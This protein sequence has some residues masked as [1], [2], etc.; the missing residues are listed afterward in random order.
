MCHV[1]ARS[2]WPALGLL[3]DSVRLAAELQAA[4]RP[5]EAVPHYEAALLQLDSAGAADIYSDLGIALN[6]A[7]RRQEAFDAYETC[8]AIN[9]NH[10]HA[11][12]NLAV[13]RQAHGNV[14]AALVAYT[15]AI[16]LM[17]GLPVLPLN[18]LRC[19]LDG[20][21][22]RAWP[23][24]E[25]LSQHEAA[26][27]AAS[28]IDGTAAW[29]WSRLEARA[30]LVDSATL[31]HAAAAAEASA[32]EAAARARWSGCHSACI[33]REAP[34]LSATRVTPHEGRQ[35][36]RVA[37]LSDLDADP[38]ASLLVD[39]LP[40]LHRSKS[41]RLSLLAT[42]SRAPS[43]HLERIS[44]EVPTYWL[45]AAPPSLDDRG[46]GRELC[47]AQGA[48]HELR[49]HIILE[50]MGYLPGQQLVLLA[51]N[52]TRAPVHTSWMR[53]FH[54]SMRAR[55]IHYTL[56]DA[57]ALTVALPKAAHG[58]ALSEAAILMPHQHLAH[59]HTQST[60]KPGERGLRGLPSTWPRYVPIAC[61]LNRV[62]KLEP[63]ILDVWSSALRRARIPIWLHT[64]AGAWTAR[65][66]REA[67]NALRGEAMARGMSRDQLLFASRSPSFSGHMKRVE[68]CALALDGRRWGAHTTALDALAVG[69]GVLSTPGE[70]LAARASHSLAHAI[71]APTLSSHSLREHSDLAHELLATHAPDGRA[72]Y[73]ELRAMRS[74]H[75][76]RPVPVE[77]D[78]VRL[79]H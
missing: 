43:E 20:A 25:R 24:L 63:S 10:G 28:A 66:R 68:R 54:G 26:P 67:N 45:P 14:D 56:V 64:G 71:G 18:A 44:R 17:P 50:A 39:V 33:H 11:Y 75:R 13:A 73:D 61:S 31:L 32:V 38:S 70:A 79:R 58:R 48:L 36:L 22:W 62:N 12:N 47:E 9:P 46:A 7:G 52:C 15:Q 29:P 72:R 59:S 55:F 40:L 19:K 57:R 35:P 65:G 76:L 4:G 5:A 53:A 51:R 6:Q 1:I 42:P 34:S 78:S 77:A 23:Q 37:L 49:P 74:R 60:D 30:F 8:L 69:V 3:M 2:E 21:R 41:I 27:D 16:R